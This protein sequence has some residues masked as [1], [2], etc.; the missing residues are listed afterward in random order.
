MTVPTALSQYLS[1][2]LDSTYMSS[3]DTIFATVVLDR[4]EASMNINTMAEIYSGTRRVGRI[5]IRM[6]VSVLGA[7]IGCETAADGSL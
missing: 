5:P 1:I 3:N 6:G 4:V 7:A 2:R